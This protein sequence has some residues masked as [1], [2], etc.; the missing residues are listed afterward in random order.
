MSDTGSAEELLLAATAATRRG[1]LAA[2]ES[3]ASAAYERC[4]AA[5]NLD[6]RMRALNLLGVIRFERGAP[7]EAEGAFAEAL[8]LARQLRDTLMA[9]RASNNLASVFHLQGQ[10]H[11]ALGLYRQV[12]L[13]YQRLGDRRGTAE[14][15]HNIGLVHR[16]LRA[17]DEAD[18]ATAESLRHAD[19]AGDRGMLGIAM[20]GKAELDLD[21]GDL[22]L[23]LQELERAGELARETGD[24]VGGAQIEMLRAVAALKRGDY[25]AARE[26]AGSALAL[27][28]DLGVPLLEAE[29]T[30]V[31]A[32]AARALGDTAEA[33]RSRAQAIE[34]FTRLGAAGFIQRFEAD[35]GEV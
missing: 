12:L 30:G 14:T 9:A 7:G 20:A 1:E 2:A 34:L 26:T 32:R 3:Q 13:D 11:L 35:Y 17:W 28:R 29:A 16:Q 4:R 18:A 31:A 10:P 25:A 8:E 23:A 5:G 22:A 15:W 6:G 27:T 24:E 21:R 33:E 19:L